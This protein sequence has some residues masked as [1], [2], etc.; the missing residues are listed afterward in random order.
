MRLVVGAAALAGAAAWLLARRHHRPAQGPDDELEP[1]MP[2]SAAPTDAAD[3]VRREGVAVVTGA[4]DH[5]ELEPLRRR[6]LALEPL[7]RQNRR[8]LRTELVH[9]PSEPVYA[10]LAARP[11]IREL[12][13]LLLG[14]RH[15]LEKAGLIVAEPGAELQRWHMDTPHL[16]ATREH[17]P[18]HSVS[19]FVPLCELTHANGPTE[20]ELATHRKINLTRPRRRVP[21]VCKIG[22]L[23]V[24]DVRV[25][26]RGGANTSKVERPLVYMTFSRVWYRDTLNP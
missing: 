5:D 22:A 20:F 15:Y 21:A 18:P 10:E 8:K 23:V 12:V 19:L 2:H 9:S 4:F 25:L 11:I 6:V 13:A 26:H 3:A 16:F 1:S 24:Y 17:L 7:K 14:P